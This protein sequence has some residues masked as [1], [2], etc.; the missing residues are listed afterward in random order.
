MADSG[1]KERE[2]TG[3]HVFIGF[4]VAFGVIIAVNLIL[5]VSAVKTF[6]GLEAKNSYVASQEFDLRKSAQM[7]LGWQVVAELQ[8]K[9][10]VLSIT[11]A[12]GSPVEVKQLSAVLGRPTHVQDDSEPDF[13]FNGTAY[14]A[15]I[16]LDDGNWN[17]RMVAIATDGTEF[18]QRVQML[19][20]R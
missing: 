14:V 17:I 2:I 5:A 15:P 13:V 10:L 18:R 7:A 3:R 12:D 6:P 8:G 11:D 4:V 16:E 20:K 1:K 9:E 19:V